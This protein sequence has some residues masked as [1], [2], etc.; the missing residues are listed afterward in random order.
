MGKITIWHNSR[1]S[2]S[3]ATFKLLEDKNLEEFLNNA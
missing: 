3:R 1:C 2:K